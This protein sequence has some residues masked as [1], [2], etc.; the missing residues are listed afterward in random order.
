ML[1]SP[2]AHAIRRGTASQPH[3]HFVRWQRERAVETERVRELAEAGVTSG[4]AYVRPGDDAPT[5]PMRST[6][7]LVPVEGLRAHRKRRAEE[8]EQEEAML[9]AEPPAASLAV[10]HA[11]PQM[12]MLQSVV[13]VS[14][15][16]V[17]LVADVLARAGDDSDGAARLVEQQ[18]TLVSAA[19]L[20]R[21]AL[22][23]LGD[24]ASRYVGT[25]VA[26]TCTGAATSVGAS[27]L[28]A[29]ADARAA[30]V[31]ARKKR[32]RNVAAIA[33]P[34]A[35]ADAP[36]KVAS[37]VMRLRVQQG[38][39]PAWQQFVSEKPADWLSSAGGAPTFEMTWEFIRIY[40]GIKQ[41]FDRVW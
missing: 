21:V 24:A 18:A 37:V 35:P 41:L 30:V 38:V 20:A 4:A 26:V 7:V 8:S 27:S 9:S 34:L 22:T 29:V 3:E 11:V 19:G 15:S 23:E 40:R 10:S 5:H 36:D 32:P 6:G 12:P 1:R 33:L 17:E 25:E 39:F 13:A 14:R 2:A 28:D 16:S 31:A